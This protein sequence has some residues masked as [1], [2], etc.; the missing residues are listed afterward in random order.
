MH[1]EIAM[2]CG[3]ASIRVREL[4]KRDGAK[5][6]RARSAGD[7]LTEPLNGSGKERPAA[8]INMKSYFCVS[9]LAAWV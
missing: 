8:S 5:P 1:A 6:R 2:S 4:A 7:A 9:A 3:Y